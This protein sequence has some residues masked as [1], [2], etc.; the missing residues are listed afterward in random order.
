MPKPR[1]DEQKSDFIARFMASDEARADY[2]DEKQRVAVA[3]SL[4]EHRGA[5]EAA[6]ALGYNA[7][8]D[9]AELFRGRHLQPGVVN[10]PEMKHP[11]TGK[12]GI[13]VLMEKHVIDAMRKSAEGVPVI[14]WAHD[15]S[16]GAERWIKEGKAVGVM[17][18]SSWDG[19]DAWEH[20]SFMLWDREAKENARKGFRLSN[21]WKDDEIEWTP[22][23]HNGVPY[24]GRLKAPRYTHLAIVPN[25]RYE[26]AVIYANSKGGAADMIMKLLGLGKPEGVTLDKDAPIEVDGKKHT[27]LEVV[28]AL[29][30]AEAA[31]ASLKVPSPAAISDGDSVEV[32]GKKYTG[33]EVKNALARAAAAA[34]APAA[35]PK[36]ITMTEE[37]FQN[38]VNEK[39]KAGLDK[40]LADMEGH[41]FF[42]AVAKLAQLRPGESTVAEPKARSER[43]RV[44]EGRKRYGAGE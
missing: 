8:R 19:E 30:A 41:A 31:A 36:K 3:E 10:Y 4:W 9:G 7:E 38:S 25:P 27:A 39:V 24:D 1:A 23:F 17:V 43:E 28:N 5:L 33:L 26:G 34:P 37:E 16:K 14:N 11:V 18:G 6:N 29:K 22:G 20:C 12:Q 15:M 2:P 44:K 21:A 35:E 32:D 40:A 42:N 13:A